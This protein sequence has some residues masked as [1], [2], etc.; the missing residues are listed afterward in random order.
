MRLLILKGIRF[1][2]LAQH[3]QTAQNFPAL[4]LAGIN[5]GI[6]CRHLSTLIGSRILRIRRS[7]VK[8][9]NAAGNHGI[10]ICI[11][12]RADDILAGKTAFDREIGRI[13]VSFL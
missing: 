12:T 10:H 9:S 2:S 6:A 3:Q 13:C 4:E 8:H 7:A 5:D 11:G 1:I